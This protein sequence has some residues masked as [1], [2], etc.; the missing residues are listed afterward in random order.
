MRVFLGE[1]IIR[2]EKPLFLP[3]VVNIIVPGSEIFGGLTPSRCW[4]YTLTSGLSV[5]SGESTIEQLTRRAQAFSFG[6]RRSVDLW[7]TR[8]VPPDDQLD[9]VLHGNIGR[10][11][12]LLGSHLTGSASLAQRTTRVRIWNAE[13]GE[14]PFEGH[15]IGVTSVGLS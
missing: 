9:L 13:T 4:T 5:W 7:T 6:Q 11:S 12:Y 10:G 3:I 15:T 1:I 2:R 8:N 14:G